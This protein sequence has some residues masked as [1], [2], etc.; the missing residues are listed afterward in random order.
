MKEELKTY[1]TNLKGWRHH[2]EE[3]DGT[4]MYYLFM[5]KQGKGYR[6]LMNGDETPEDI[7]EYMLDINQVK[8]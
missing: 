7:R 6:M 4:H 3:Q 5:G 8:L 2:T 1:L